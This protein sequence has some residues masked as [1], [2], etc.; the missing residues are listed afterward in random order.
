MTAPAIERAVFQS[1]FSAYTPEHTDTDMP[2]PSLESPNSTWT[3]QFDFTLTWIVF[4]SDS[5]KK[6]CTEIQIHEY[7]H[8]DGDDILAGGGGGGVF[9]CF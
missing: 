5:A 3:V 2:R 6:S 9:W 1:V 7:P 4:S 8:V